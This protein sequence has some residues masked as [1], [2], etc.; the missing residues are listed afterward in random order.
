[1]SPRFILL[2]ALFAGFASPAA[3]QSLSFLPKNS[4]QPIVV[5]AE[6]GIEV[7]QDN[8]RVIARGN[9]KATQGEVSIVGDEL[10]AYYRTGD[11]GGEE[12]YRVFAVGNVT[13]RS[14]EET[15]TG[16]SAI[17]DFDKGVLVLE[18]DQVRLANADGTV[19]A[20]KA[21][22]YWA[23][24]RVAVAEGNA[25]AEDSEKRRVFADKLVAFFRDEPGNAASKGVA[26]AAR[27]RGDITYMQGF[28]NV[29]VETPRETARGERATYNI[30]T[31]VVTLDGNVK[32]TQDKNV[33]SG[34]FAVVNIKGGRSAVYGSAKEAGQTGTRE[35]TRVS[36]LIAPSSRPPEP[37]TA[38]KAKP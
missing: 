26:S 14:A 13:M 3:A 2:A 21:L 6:R 36:A 23:S 24:E 32:L 1:M 27:G 30:Q 25:V 16:A 5:D 29:R 31:G 4:D 18:G 8:K 34:G 19:S 33:L 11:G 20:Q 10:I 9:A 22:Q 37:A 35:N 12:V 28:G 15:A 17:Y 38:V 7:Q